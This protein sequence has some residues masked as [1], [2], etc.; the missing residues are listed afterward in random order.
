MLYVPMMAITASASKIGLST[1]TVM[2]LP[3]ALSS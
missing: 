1:L 2:E 3:Q